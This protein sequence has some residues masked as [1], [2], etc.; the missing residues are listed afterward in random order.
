[1]RDG[2]ISGLFETEPLDYV[3]AVNA[4]LGHQ[5]TEV[6]IDPVAGGD[7][8][9]EVD[10]VRLHENGPQIDLTARE[11]EVV[12]LTG[13]LGSGTTE[14]AGTA[15][16]SVQADVTDDNVLLQASEVVNLTLHGSLGEYSSRFLE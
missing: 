2:A 1:M 12:A 11:G 7:P 5:M 16:G 10:G 15:G 8:I 4:M 9:L 6:D 14:E 3:G 13:L